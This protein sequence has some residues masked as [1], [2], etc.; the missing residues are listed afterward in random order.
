MKKLLL[1]FMLIVTSIASWAAEPYFEVIDG[2]FASGNVTLKI[3]FPEATSVAVDGSVGLYHP[4]NTPSYAAVAYAY[5]F[6]G[7]VTTDGNTLTATFKSFN[8]FSRELNYAV[9]SFNL[10]VDGSTYDDEIYSKESMP[11]AEVVSDGGFTNGSV[12]I[13]VTMPRFE[14]VNSRNRTYTYAK[15]LDKGNQ[16]SQV[17]GTNITTDGN[18]F[19]A[20]FT[21]YTENDNIADYTIAVDANLLYLD[22]D[23][24]AWNKAFTIRLGEDDPAPDPSGCAHENLTRH[25]EVE[26]TD[27]IQGHSAYDQCDDC[28]ACFATTDTEHENALT[29]SDFILPLDEEPIDYF[30]VENL[31]PKRTMIGVPQA[32]LEYRL[33]GGDGVWR[34]VTTEP[35]STVNNPAYKVEVPAY[36]KV[37]LRATTASNTSLP[38][39]FYGGDKYSFPV[40]EWEGEPNHSQLIDIHYTDSRV[41]YAIG[42]DI[43]TL[44]RSNGK[45]KTLPEPTVETDGE[46]NE[47]KH[48]IFENMFVN[49]GDYLNGYL[50][51]ASNLKLPSTTLS[52]RCYYKMFDR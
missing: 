21:L 1:L 22:G 31:D 48:G 30:Y 45:V 36:G 29:P 19:S 11:V 7:D 42:G 33:E 50:V 18:T 38:G 35:E 13:E 6:Y 5:D 46:D 4:E 20:T 40:F 28:G 51:D 16:V 44:L 34:T 3:T 47:I 41:H 9:R 27:Q 26:S 52:E 25:E 23:E 10:T 43:T 12:T 2:S 15:L 32:N 14:T 8:Y 24:N 37:Y 49:S 39:S 17:N